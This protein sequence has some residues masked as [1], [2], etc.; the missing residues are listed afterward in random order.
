M[1]PELICKVLVSKAHPVRPG[2]GD[3]IV[4]EGHEQLVGLHLSVH[5]FQGSVLA[6][7]VESGHQGI[8][9]L[10]PFRL[11]YDV[12]SPV[13]VMPHI[14]FLIREIYYGWCLRYL[15]S[16]TRPLGPPVSAGRRGSGRG[17]LGGPSRRPS[18]VGLSKEAPKPKASRSCPFAKGGGDC[19]TRSLRDKHSEKSTA[20]RARKAARIAALRS[21]GNS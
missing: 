16:R 8:T 12:C 18:E 15:H 14:F 9:L 4:K 5:C 11:L 1:G 20:S 19:N 10:P 21:R 7:G 17:G 6:E 13:C 3:H 2:N